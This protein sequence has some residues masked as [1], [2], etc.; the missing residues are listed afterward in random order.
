MAHTYE[1]NAQTTNPDV[2]A[3]LLVAGLEEWD[4]VGSTYMLGTMGRDGDAMLAVY[5]ACRKVKADCILNFVKHN[6]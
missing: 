1:V 6:S 2:R 5:M 4:K 3:A